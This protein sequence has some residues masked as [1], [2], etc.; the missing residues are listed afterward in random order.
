MIRKAG[1]TG[2]LVAIAGSAVVAAGGVASAEDMT[3]AQKFAQQLSAE[4]PSVLISTGEA[5]QDP[6]GE[7]SAGRALDVLIEN[8]T[9][10]S[11]IELGNQVTSRVHELGAAGAP[12]EYTLWRLG[13]QAL[14]QPVTPVES[15][16]DATQ[17]H[18]NNVHIA[19]TTAIC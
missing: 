6:F 2:V 12:V 14:G 7:H 11:Q 10:P 18:E 1:I 16:G 5:R 19:L 4:F 13:Y 15:R 17:N 3:C 8:H 9:D